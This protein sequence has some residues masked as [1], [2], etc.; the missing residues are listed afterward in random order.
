MS[1]FKFKVKEFK[2]NVYDFSQKKYIDELI[3]GIDLEDPNIKIAQLVLN[4]LKDK[5]NEFSRFTLLDE[6]GQEVCFLQTGLYPIREFKNIYP[7][8]K[9]I[10]RKK[11][12][13][14]DTILIYNDFKYYIPSAIHHKYGPLSLL[15]IENFVNFK[16]NQFIPATN[17]KY[18][19][20]EIEVMSDDQYQLLTNL[21]SSNDRDSLNLLKE[22]LFLHDF[23]TNKEKIIYIL[24]KT[25][26]NFY[27]PTGIKYKA[28]KKKIQKEFPRVNI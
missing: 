19:S 24:A 4:E 8:V 9:R 20:A 13:T 15:E 2:K 26:W 16:D 23:E 14:K 7:N 10:T 1:E 6:P 3:Q 22:L 28:L 25:N 21:A 17:L 12:I 18:T 11:D 5:H 27:F